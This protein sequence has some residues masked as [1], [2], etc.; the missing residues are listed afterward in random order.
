MKF[1]LPIALGLGLLST[2]ALAQPV[3]VELFQSQGCSSCPPAIANVNALAGRPDILALTFAVTYWDNLGWKDTFA[4]PA[5]TGRQ[6][7]YA[8]G[9]HHANVYTPQVVIDGRSDLD[10]TQRGPLQD[11]IAHAVSKTGPAL[12]WASGSVTVEAAKGEGDVWLVRYDPRLVDVAIHAGENSG[13]TIA[14]RNVVRELTL[15]GHWTGADR[16]FAI[17]PGNPDWRTAVLVQGQ[18]G[19]PIFSAAMA[20]AP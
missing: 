4:K 8:H 17:A 18:D 7:A 15:L 19:G 10:G 12:S 11:A 9:L 2:P 6:Y 20:P 3:V 16:K 1:A 13:V 14:H 5:F